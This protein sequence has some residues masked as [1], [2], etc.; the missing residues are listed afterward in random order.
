MEIQ[1]VFC[2][3]RTRFL[4]ISQLKCVLQSR[5][6]H[7]SGFSP[8]SFGFSLRPV[9]LRFMAN[10]VV[11]GQ[12]FLCILQFSSV[13]IIPW[14]LHTHL[15]LNIIL[16]RRTS[17]WKL[18]TS[19]ESSTLLEIGD[20]WTE[21]YFQICAMKGYYLRTRGELTLITW[22][23]SATMDNVQ[24]NIGKLIQPLPQT[25]ENH[26]RESVVVF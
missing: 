1:S 6:C 14:K 11:L 18:V 5:L 20:Q 4:N 16:I 12:V 19:K 10:T 7:G 25:L 15:H 23:I 26:W 22:C 3:V 21:K 17:G 2:E 24:H 9:H 8:Q 13:S